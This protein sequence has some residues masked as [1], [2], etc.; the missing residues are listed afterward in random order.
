MAGISSRSMYD[1]CFLK[2]STNTNTLQS[3]YSFLLDFNVNKSMVNTKIPVCNHTINKDRQCNVCAANSNADISFV[4]DNFGKLI[5]IDT[6]L[7][8]IG[9]TVNKCDNEDLSA[10][11][12]LVAANPIL[13]DRDIIPTNLHR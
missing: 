8:G 12:S 13:C 4:P 6:A 3:N 5:E 7:K 11:K 10:L 2:Q 9:L 1:D